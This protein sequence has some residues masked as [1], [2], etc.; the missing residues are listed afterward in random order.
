MVSEIEVTTQAKDVR[1]ERDI[2]S[3]LPPLD[4]DPER[5]HQVLFNLVG[6]FLFASVL[7]IRRYRLP[8]RE[9]LAAYAQKH[10]KLN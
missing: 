4:A 7:M 6:V 3:D 2:P 5:V 10:A 1:I 9:A 8:V